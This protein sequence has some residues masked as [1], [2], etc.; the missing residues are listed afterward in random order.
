MLRKVA[1]FVRKCFGWIAVFLLSP[2]I[3]RLFWDVLH[4]RRD[5][6]INQF[7]DELIKKMD[8]LKYLVMFFAWTA[9][10][11]ILITMW[12]A[13]GVILFLFVYGYIETRRDKIRAQQTLLKVDEHS[14][15]PDGEAFKDKLR[16]LY[17]RLSEEMF[18]HWPSAEAVNLYRELA[19]DFPSFQTNIDE[20]TRRFFESALMEAREDLMAKGVKDI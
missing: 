7:I 19:R 18:W 10:N 2:S 17:Q 9:D 11:Y 1:A 4:D 8:S 12:S 6:L 3:S 13:L 5:N 20:D 16:Q 15:G 14:T